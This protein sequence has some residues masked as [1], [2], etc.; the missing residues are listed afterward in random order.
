MQFTKYSLLQLLVYE[1]GGGSDT[2]IWFPIFH[3][4]QPCTSFLNDYPVALVPAERQLF[5]CSQQNTYIFRF[6]LHYQV[7]NKKIKRKHPD[8]IIQSSYGTKGT[9]R[10]VLT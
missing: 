1:T 8:L 5:K 2:E 7:E 6:Q 9:L 4:L 10:G 3:Q